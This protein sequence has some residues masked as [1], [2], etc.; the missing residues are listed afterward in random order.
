VIIIDHGEI[1]VDKPMSEIENLEE[2]FKQA[3]KNE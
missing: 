3:T 2:T 1:K